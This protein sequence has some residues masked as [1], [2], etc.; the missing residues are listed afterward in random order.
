M[1]PAASHDSVEAGLKWERVTMAL[2][3]L[4]PDQR[5]AIVLAYFEG[6]AREDIAR[7]TGALVVPF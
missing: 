5:R 1:L 6:L 7:R 4:A 2:A 3:G